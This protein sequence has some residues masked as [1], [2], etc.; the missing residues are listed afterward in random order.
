MVAG[1]AAWKA[2]GLRPPEAVQAETGDYKRSSDSVAAWIDD[3]CKVDDQA[4]TG[5]TDLF[6]SYKDWCC[7]A[8]FEALTQTSFGR[9]LEEM[10]YQKDRPTQGIH[11]NKVVRKGLALAPASSW[12]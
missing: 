6:V 3:A 5:S 1:F 2:S 7:R 11:R 8:G 4:A 12:A 10:G 9:A